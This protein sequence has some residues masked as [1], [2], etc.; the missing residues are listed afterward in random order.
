MAAAFRERRRHLAFGI[1]HSGRVFQRPAS[2][3]LGWLLAAALGARVAIAGGAWLHPERF[4]AEE[5]SVEYVRLARNLAAGHGFSQSAA[6][7]YE[8]DVRRTPVYPSMLATV[9]LLPGA[10]TRTAAIAGIAISVLTVVATFGLARALAGPA[11]AS[12]AAALIAIDLTSAAYAGQVLTEP[13]FTL[14]LVLSFA[15]LVEREPDPS[16]SRAAVSAGALSG[17]AALCRPIAVLAFAALAPACRLRSATLSGAARLFAI[18]TV[19][20]IALTAGWTLRNYRATGTAT[21]SSVAATNMYFHRAAYV[22]AYLQNRRVEDL[23]DEWQRDFE[24]R[25]STWTE[26]ERLQWMND[27]GRGAVL[28]HPFVYGWV[29]LR[30][31]ARMLTPDHIVLSALTGGYGSAAFRILRGA[32]W[33][34]LAIVYVLAAAGARRLWRVSPLRAAVLA[35]PIAYFL[36]I[37]GPEM[38]PRFRVPIM[39]FICVFAGAGL[40]APVAER[41]S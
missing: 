10:G 15:P 26:R 13:L 38:Y 27:H 31:A 17:L 30:S 28:R 7:P 16:R 23:R 18:V 33:I 1:R 36:L 2:G 14:L 9:F 4:L 20:A 8:P 12:W 11:T 5:D 24:A 39:P 37:G 3:Y 29:A 34:Q 32:G 22:E 41:A 25:S 35:A 6:A 19:T 21:V 40:A